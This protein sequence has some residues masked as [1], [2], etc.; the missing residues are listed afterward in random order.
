MG[1][2]FLSAIVLLTIVLAV[3][4]T[5]AAAQTGAAQ[6]TAAVSL[7]VVPTTATAASP[8]PSIDH[9]FYGRPAYAA[10][11]ISSPAAPPPPPSAPTPSVAIAKPAPT[12]GHSHPFNA[13]EPHSIDHYFYG[14]PAR[15]TPAIATPVAAAT[16]AATPTPAAA[17]TAIAAVI[18]PSPPAVAIPTPVGNATPAAPADHS[19]EGL[20]LYLSDPIS[21]TSSSFNWTVTAYKSR[22]RIEVFYKRRLYK[23]YH[24]VFGRSRFAGPKQWEGDRRTPEGNYLIVSRHR[25]AR[26]RWFLKINYPNA[27]DQANFVQAKADGDIPGRMHEGD[28]V[29]IHGTDLPILNVGNID[30]TT[31]CISIDNDDISELARLLPIG[32]LVT[33]KP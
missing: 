10:P 26:F 7:P 22:H 29:G 9:V 3:A 2:L 11:A 25:S 1:K 15:A 16:S 30:W 6:P 31:G 24:A 32:T 13:L 8:T 4:P 17:P 12:G 27:I 33:I 20:R 5:S 23:S 28:G 21:A 14:L 18:P 19:D